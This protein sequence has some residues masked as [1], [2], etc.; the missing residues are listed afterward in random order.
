MKFE[1]LFSPMQVG[2]VTYRNRIVSAP[3]AFG[4]IVQNPDARDFTYRKLE[5]S[6][7]GGNGCVIVG[8]TDV[9]FTDAV[10]I[11]GFR[12]FDFAKPEEDPETFDAVGEYARRIKRHGAVALAELVHC[13]KE[14]VPFGPGQEAIGPIETTNLVG[15]RVR[16]MNE[17]DMPRIARDFAVSATYMQKAGFDGVLIHGGHGF[18]FTQFLSP[19]M[20]TRTDSYGGSLENRARFPL[21]ILKAVRRRWAPTSWWS[22]ASTAPTTSPAASPPRRPARSSPWPSPTSPPST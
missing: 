9:N 3:M 4:L 5:A 7:K 22:C 17:D 13:G 18:L 12:P 2:K 21:Q 20:N 6:A 8:E 11:P 15:V 19:L 10:R 14:K 1:H 16:P